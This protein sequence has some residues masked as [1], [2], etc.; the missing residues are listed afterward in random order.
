VFA[1]TASVARWWV[2]STHS[3]LLASGITA[4][5][6]FVLGYFSP[7]PDDE[8]EDDVHVRPDEDTAVVAATDADATIADETRS[9]A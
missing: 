6:F 3:W 1:F 8:D 2:P 7:T 5:T 9:E 4:A